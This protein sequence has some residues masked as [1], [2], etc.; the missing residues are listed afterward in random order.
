MN[1]EEAIFGFLRLGETA[2]KVHPSVNVLAISLGFR[3]KVIYAYCIYLLEGL[4]GIRL[5][6]M[7]HASSKH[8]S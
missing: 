3:R 1:L 2:L 8:A 5:K 6:M 4:F 7:T